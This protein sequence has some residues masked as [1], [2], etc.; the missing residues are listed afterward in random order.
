RLPAK[1]YCNSSASFAPFGSAL[2]PGNLYPAP[3]RVKGGGEAPTALGCQCTRSSPVTRIDCDNRQVEPGEV[4]TSVS[5][6]G[7]PD[8]SYDRT[9]RRC[10]RF[11]PGRRSYA[12]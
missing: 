11:R 9:G 12:P 1:G 5:L 6:P 3:D 10:H 8:R 2:T 4:G 7:S